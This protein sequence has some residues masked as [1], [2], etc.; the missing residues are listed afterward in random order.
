MAITQAMWIHGHSIKVEYPT[1][2]KSIWRAGF[3]ARIVGKPST[4]NWFHFSIPTTV[5]VKDK[6]QMI[7]SV[8]LRFKSGSGYAKVTSV[9]IYDGEAKIAAHDG[10]N[11]HPNAY[12]LERFDVPGKPDIHW[13]VGISVGVSFTGTTDAQNTMEFSS[14]GCDFNLFESVR[15]HVKVLT[16]PTVSIDQMIS[17]MRQVYEPQGFRVLRMSDENLNLP[18]LNTVDVGSCVRGSTTAEQDTLFGNRNNV[19]ANDVVAYFVLATN[20]P[21]N[22]CAAHPDGRPGAVIASGATQWTLG[23]EIG[24]VLGL[25]HVNDNNRL[26]TGN[27]TANITNPPPDLINSEI[28]TMKNSSLSVNP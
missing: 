8:M 27:G 10:L 3:Y 19:G 15:L 16:T 13:G 23:H 18:T 21:Y 4:T 14:A 22:G 9:H 7:D 24:H 25:S 12:G 11:L 20:P 28:T 17:A 6:R 26:M 1:R 5:I 2:I